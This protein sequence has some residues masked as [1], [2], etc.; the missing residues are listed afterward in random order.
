M[1][2]YFVIS[3]VHGFFTEMRSCLFRAGFRKQNPEHILVLVGDA[4]DRGPDAPKVYEYI[5]SLPRKRR[6]LI[7]GNHELLLRNAIRRGVFY[8]NDYYN[9]TLGT[10][11]QFTGHEYIDCV[12]DPQGVCDKF[13]KNGVLD[14]IFG[15]EWQNYA[16]IGSY[17][18]VHSWIPVKI[19]DGTEIYDVK[20][21]TEL[22]YRPDWREAT[23]EEWEEASWG[24]P[25]VMAEKGLMPRGYTI[26]CGHWAACEFPK[27]LDKNYTNYPNHSIYRGHGCIALDATTVRSGFVNVLVLTEEELHESKGSK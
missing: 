16:E 5:R 15:P 9:G 3:D 13:K 20:R 26:V 14:W 21:S 27:N 25:W 23:Q 1:K 2:K 7:R 19:L 22:A 8:E 12:Y 10:I 6:I 4:F 17:I 18:F 24:C 11:M